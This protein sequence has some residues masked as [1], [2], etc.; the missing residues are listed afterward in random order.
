[1]KLEVRLHMIM[2][3]F[4]FAAITAFFRTDLFAQENEIALT[5]EAGFYYTIQKGDTLW[6]LSDQFF[7]SP[8]IWPD[9]WNK[10]RQIPN[11][12]WIYPGER[13]RLYQGEGTDK[14]TLTPPMQPTSVTQK[15]P[16]EKTLYYLYATIDQ[17]GFIKKTAV[18]AN[19]SIFKVAGDHD[20]I[21]TGDMVYIQP[22][23]G[24]TLIPGSRHTVYR[25][26]IPAAGNAYR[27][28]AGI[29]HYL[30]GVVEII[31]KE[32]DFVIARVMNAYREIKIGDSLLP[33]R[34]RD[35]K[36]PLKPSPDDIEALVIVSEEHSQLIGENTTAFIDKGNKN[37]IEP[38]QQYSVYYQDT[39]KLGS[40]SD[41]TVLLN[42]VSF[43][44]LLVL[45]TEETTSTVIVTNSKKDIHPGD[46]VCSPLQ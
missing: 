24:K 39:K 8:W 7:D 20:M 35:S 34:P 9:L 19:G 29:Q 27:S 44:T 2:F 22:A 33:F 43:G 42:P 10:N 21:S 40:G 41:K 13:I 30:T 18:S 6:D 11:P 14:L 12:H 16:A 25:T 45:H 17:V 23:N 28:T 1:M 26:M 36:I 31:K 3:C 37:G 5:H 38:G 15:E 46:K 4:I 32:P